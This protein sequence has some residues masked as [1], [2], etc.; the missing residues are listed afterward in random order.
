[1]PTVADGGDATAVTRR[2]GSMRATVRAGARW[3]RAA[4]ALIFAGGVGGTAAPAASGEAAKPAGLS[5]PS[6]ESTPESSMESAAD[7]SR[8]GA[9]AGTVRTSA[10]WELGIMGAGFYL[11]DYPAA[12]QNHLRGL[13]LPWIVY[14]GKFFRG[15]EESVRGRV[16]EVDR[17]E[18]D[19]SAAGILEGQSRPPGM[20]DLD[21][22]GEIG[23]RLQVK[24]VRSADLAQAPQL[25]FE[26]PVRGVFSTDFGSAAPDWRGVLIAPGLVWRKDDLFA[27][28]TD[29]RLAT[30]AMFATQEFMDYSYTVED[31]YARPGRPAYKADLGYL[32]SRLAAGMEQRGH[33]KPERIRQPQLG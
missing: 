26:L 13:P 19:I 18:F 25:T 17:V 29:V 23:P 6:V 8:A 1:V 14:R 32:G 30:R 5:A 22:L 31:R 28:G 24:L 11:P 15:D 21:W 3:A 27:T 2:P 7:S 33:R 20:P 9:P 12:D 4:A 16:L 10:L